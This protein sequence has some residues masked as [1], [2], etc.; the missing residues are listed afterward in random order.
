[1]VR[2]ENGMNEGMQRT[3]DELVYQMGIEMHRKWKMVVLVRGVGVQPTKYA[4]SFSAEPPGPLN[5]C[6]ARHSTAC[7]GPADAAG[8]RWPRCGSKEQ[9][10]DLARDIRVPDDNN[11]KLRTE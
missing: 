9:T 1:M 11:N 8:T 3:Y 4:G 10:G 7:Q 5:P 2:F 6:R